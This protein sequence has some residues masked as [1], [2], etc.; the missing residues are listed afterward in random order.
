[1]SARPM[2]T[3]QSEGWNR[4]IGAG[5]EH[6]Y[7]PHVVYAMQLGPDGVVSLCGGWASGGGIRPWLTPSPADPSL[8]CRKCS[9]IVAVQLREPWDA[10]WF[11]ESPDD[12]GTTDE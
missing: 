8:V 5:V 4:P 2:S 12:R 10:P 3:F 9:A 6:Y 1:M 7:R 11:S